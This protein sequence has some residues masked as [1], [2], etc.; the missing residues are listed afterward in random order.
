MLSPQSACVV[1][2]EQAQKITTILWDPR[3]N[4]PECQRYYKHGPQV[5]PRENVSGK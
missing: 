4:I 5:Q 1:P 3:F 2:T